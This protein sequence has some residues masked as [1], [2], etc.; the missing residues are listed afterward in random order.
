MRRPRAIRAA[1]ATVLAAGVAAPLVRR[2]VPLPRPVVGTA[3]AAAPFA[4][5]VL[6]PRSRARDAATVGLQMLAY[7]WG[8]EAPNDDPERYTGFA[9]GMGI[10]RIAMLKHG[11]P[12]LRLLYDNDLRMLEQFG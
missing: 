7:L 9:W 3:A 11:V 2:R 5:C 10:E 12:D 1:A 4:L 8:Y 6:V